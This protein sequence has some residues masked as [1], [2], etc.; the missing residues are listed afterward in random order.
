MK[1]RCIVSYDW[2]GTLRTE[3]QMLVW[4]RRRVSVQTQCWRNPRWG[5]GGVAQCLLLLLYHDCRHGALNKGCVNC[6]SS[7]GKQV[8]RPNAKT[9]CIQIV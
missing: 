8:Y 7:V 1:W 6:V 4:N 9:E 2:G 3:G 5:R